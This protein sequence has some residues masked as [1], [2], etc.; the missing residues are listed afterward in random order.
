MDPCV[1]GKRKGCADKIRLG[2]RGPRSFGKEPS[3]AL[4]QKA[5][6]RPELVI[7]TSHV[8]LEAVLAQLENR[9]SWESY[10]LARGEDPSRPQTRVFVDPRTGTVTN[11][12][13]AFPLIP[14]NG[15]G[16]KVTAA[17]LARALGR[18]IAAVDGPTVAAAV[19]RFVEERRSLLG[20]DTRQFGEA[21]VTQISVDLWQI[22]IPQ[23]FGGVPVRDGRLAASISHGNLVVIGTEVWA[24]VRQAST[25]RLSAEGALAAGFAYADGRAEEFSTQKKTPRGTHTITIVGTS[26][27]LS[28]TTTVELVVNQ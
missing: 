13:G 25:S 23:T 17:G 1:R 24:D 20:I 14:G 15:V 16:N 18:P 10:L 4:D 19:R 27:S 11:L 21:R 3:A 5:F 7:T 8:S 2:D 26:G 6:Y 22:S 12:L 9:T 28:H